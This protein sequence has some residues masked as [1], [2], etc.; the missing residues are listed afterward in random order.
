MSALLTVATALSAS[1]PAVAETP[2]LT[3]TLS[4]AAGPC[5]NQPRLGAPCLSR[6]EPAS[7]ARITLARDGD[8]ARDLTLDSS[9]RFAV[10]LPPGVWRIALAPG[11]P[12][13]RMAPRDVTIPADGAVSVDIDVTA[14]RP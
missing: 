1:A 5:G 13:L 3:G 12:A 7:G 8:A 6:R 2:N 9:G 14:L 11:Q 10:T 4:L